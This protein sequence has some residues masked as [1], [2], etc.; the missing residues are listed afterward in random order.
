MKTLFYAMSGA[1][2]ALSLTLSSCKK[3]GPALCHCNPDDLTASVSV[4]SSGFNNPRGLKFGPDGYLYVAEGGVGG[5]NTSTTCTQ[6]LP[7]VGPYTGSTTG[8]RISRVGSSGIRTT[9]VDS[10]PSSQTAVTQ[11][12][13]ISG[14]ADVSFIGHTL[15]AIFAGAGCSHGVP[16][17]PNGVIRIKPDRSWEMIA[18]L[19]A[20]QMSHPVKNPNPPDFEP[21][22]TWYSMID[23]DG[24]LYAVEP[25]HG[26]LDKITTKGVVS[27]VIDISAFEGHIVPTA[28]AFHNG[29]FYVG[30]LDVFPITGISSIYKITP[31]GAISVVATGF[32]TILGV[33]FDPAGGMYV[34][35][36]TTGNPF[37]T[38][39]AGDII[40]VDPSGSRVTIA[41][42]LNLPTA[43]TF[44]PDGKLYVSNL[45]YGGPAGAGQILQI[46]ITCVKKGKDL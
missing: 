3:N 10:L 28:V 20:Y 4:F 13:F 27:R 5:T 34:L 12:S 44:G 30:N 31:G 1:T 33:T 21:D 19:S 23:V 22:G 37:P 40:R 8:A 38:P 43:L 29:N 14:V 2:L 11:G 42:G 18:N 32:S 15:Y 6:V 25:N 9:Y 36:N 46:D 26:E 7:P 45:G 39:M 17:I 41:S 24:S 35:E 16:S